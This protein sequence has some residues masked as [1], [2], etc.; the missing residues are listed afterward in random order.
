MQI[1]PKTIHNKTDVIICIPRVN[2]NVPRQKIFEVFSS[3]RIGF[4]DKISEIPL[5][6]DETGKRIIIKFRSWV[7]TPLSN[8]IKDRLDADKDI[9]IVYENPWYWVATKYIS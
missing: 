5:K 2:S 1:Y 9:K 8:R 3:L 7:D 6:N 4:I